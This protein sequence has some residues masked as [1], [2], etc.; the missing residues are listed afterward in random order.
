ML[1]RLGLG[2]YLISDICVCYWCAPGVF[3]QAEEEVEE[4]APK[5]EEEAVEA[6]SDSKDEL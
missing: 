4:E 1:K 5:E 3:R 6:A 2:N